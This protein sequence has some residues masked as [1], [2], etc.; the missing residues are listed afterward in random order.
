MADIGTLRALITADATNFDAA[1]AGAARKIERFSKS[2]E[3]RLKAVGQS[4]ESLGKTMTLALTVPIAA[5]GKSIDSTGIKFAQMQKRLEFATGSTEEAGRAFKFVQG[6][7]S[8]LGTD[9][10]TSLDGF[11]KFAAAARGTALEGQGTRDVFIGINSAVATLGLSADQASG[12]ITALEQILS[13][14]KVQAEEIRGQFGERIPG[15]MAIAA[16]AMGVT[17]AEFNKLLETGKV[18]AEVFLP[19]FARELQ[20]TF[21]GTAPMAV[22]A[23]NRLQNEFFLMRANLAGAGGI[24][25]A[26][27]AFKLILADTMQTIREASPQAQRLGVVIAAA[28]AAAG[29]LLFVFGKIVSMGG[30]LVGVLGS[31]VGFMAPLVGIFVSMIGPIVAVAAGLALVW[32]AFGDLINVQGALGGLLN[33]VVEGFRAVARFFGEFTAFLKDENAGMSESTRATVEFIAK[34]WLSLQIAWQAVLV[35][36]KTV[37]QGLIAGVDVLLGGFE[38]AADFLGLDF[39]KSISN[40]RSALQGWVTDIEKGKEAN[41]KAIED[42]KAQW[43]TAPEALRSDVN[44]LVDTF[45][46]IPEGIMANLESA[47]PNVIETIR[48]LISGVQEFIDTGE[49]PGIQIP[50]KIAGIEGAGEEVKAFGEDNAK[51]TK[52]T[53]KQWMEV[54]QAYG[55]VFGQVS[56]LYKKG[57][58]EQKAWAIASIITDT[59][60]AIMGA[61]ANYPGPAGWAMAAAMAA[62]GA[63]QLAKVGGGGDSST[64]VGAASPSVSEATVHPRVRESEV[65]RPIE[66]EDVAGEGGDQAGA[67]YILE[68][69]GGE[70]AITKAVTRVVKEQGIGDGSGTTLAL[71]GA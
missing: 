65:I 42:M 10:T 50:V 8:R 57:S 43:G 44:A 45:A 32:G 26:F 48:S 2:T 36:F 68:F 6:E 54:G 14:G 66:D 35:G 27:I 47:F 38:A 19:R 29:P 52:A 62:M 37:V 7:V 63:I 18:T 49:I 15:A 34:A 39:A 70:Q 69:E 21:Q 17:D 22:R 53:K 41:F 46:G 20:N 9:L 60:V 33:F 59:A 23:M 5:L 1:V 4:F 13:K 71:Q 51:T 55:N 28:A 31:V 56:S 3:A 24:G 11:S 25:Q 58:A 61:L 12:A 16:R 64:S 40:A 30:S 67:T